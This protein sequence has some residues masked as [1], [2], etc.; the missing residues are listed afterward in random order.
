MRRKSACRK[1]FKAQ[2]I[3]QAFAAYPMMLALIM[4]AGAFFKIHGLPAFHESSLV[5]IFLNFW[6]AIEA[7]GSFITFF[8]VNCPYAKTRS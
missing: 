5:I 4:Q 7:I 1:L 3:M 8:A 2:M 6:V